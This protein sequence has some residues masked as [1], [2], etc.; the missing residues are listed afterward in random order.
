MRYPIKL[1]VRKGKVRKDGTASIFLQYCYSADKR[2]LISTGAAVPPSYWNKKSGRISKELPAVYGD[3]KFLE[4]HL[5]EKLRKAEDMVDHAIKKGNVCP[6]QFLKENFKL[7]NSW[8]LDQ[9]QNREINLDVFYNIDQYVKSKEGT[10][11]RCTINVINA[12][13]GH[14]KSFEDFRKEPITFDSFDVA[15]Y[16]EFVKYLTYDIAVWQKQ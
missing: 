7:S 3:V 9:M 16:E 14:L 12:M 1:I 6:M 5:T 15:F 11:K 13:K 8:Q 2:A 10:V 4:K